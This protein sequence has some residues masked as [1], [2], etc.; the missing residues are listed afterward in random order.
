MTSN[1]ARGWV[2]VIGQIAIHDGDGNTIEPAGSTRKLLAILVAAGQTGARIDE[3]ADSFWGQDDRPSSW[4]IA[5]RVAA[6]HLQKQLPAGWRIIWTDTRVR[7]FAGE[8]LVDSWA[9]LQSQPT[10]IRTNRPFWLAHGEA[11]EG[12]EGNIMVTYAREVIDQYMPSDPENCP[13]RGTPPFKAEDIERF[14]AKMKQ[15]YR[16]IVT[17]PSDRQHIIFDMVNRDED[18][19]TMVLVADSQLAM[20]FGPYIA[21]FPQ[22]RELETPAPDTSRPGIERAWRLVADAIAARATA[23]PQRLFIANADELDPSSAEL[24]T[25]LIERSSLSD[26]RLILASSNPTPG[27]SWSE[28]VNQAVIAGCRHINGFVTNPLG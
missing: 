18:I 4:S 2:Q 8:G 17:V 23:M 21:A 5:L 13:L 9:L 16:A 19:E 24:T 28:F 12:V 3:I 1:H 15:T 6:D 27:P 22:L 10:A 7:L 14:H 25:H 26:F 11:F 20:P